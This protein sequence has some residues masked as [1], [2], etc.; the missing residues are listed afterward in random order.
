MGR[1]KETGRHKKKRREREVGLGPK[2]R[3]ERE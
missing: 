2:E 3:G 1:L